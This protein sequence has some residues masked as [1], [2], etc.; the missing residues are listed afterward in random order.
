MNICKRAEIVSQKNYPSSFKLEGRS[1][2]LTQTNDRL[3]TK[4]KQRLPS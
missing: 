4:I 3:S 2:L 1:P